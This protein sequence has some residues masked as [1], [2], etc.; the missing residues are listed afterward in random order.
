MHKEDHLK[1]KIILGSTRPM[2]FSEYPGRWIF[3][4]LKKR[5]GVDAELLDL[6]DYEMPFFDEAQSP[7]S[8]KEPYKNEAVARWTGRIAE[9]DAFIIVSPEYN[10]GP[11]GVLKNALDWV[12]Q[13]WGRKAVAF[14]SYGTVGGAR[15][16]EALRISA[17]ELQMAPIRQSVNILSQWD[18][19]ESDGSLKA[20][21]LEPYE[22]AAEG[23][24]DQLIW[25]TRALKR[26]RDGQ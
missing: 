17:I 24:I 21:A 26:A 18:L 6:R 15:A 3:G 11:S 13:E 20:G 8:K 1:I 16:V 22:K 5:E 12:Y 2:R 10:R 7:S 14:I 4:I 25:W 9:A 23:M 19:R